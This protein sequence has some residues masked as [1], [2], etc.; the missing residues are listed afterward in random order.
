MNDPYSQYGKRRERLPDLDLGQK[1]LLMKAN[2]IKTRLISKS[3][4]KMSRQWKAV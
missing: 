2:N 3:Q 1:K 4:R